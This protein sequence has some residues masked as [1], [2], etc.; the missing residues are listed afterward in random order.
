MGQHDRSEA[1]FYYFPWKI[2]V[3]ETHL[4]RLIDKAHQFR[5]CAAATERQFT[6]RR[7]GRRYLI[8]LVH[9]LFHRILLFP[10]PADIGAPV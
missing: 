2:Q 9:R 5:V 3:P 1:L 7:V 6:V 4:L 8:L 10:L